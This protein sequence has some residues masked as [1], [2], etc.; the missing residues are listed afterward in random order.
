METESAFLFV[1]LGSVGR[2][3]LTESDED[4]EQTPEH[5]GLRLLLGMR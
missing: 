4:W 1:G 5:R 3:V 2:V